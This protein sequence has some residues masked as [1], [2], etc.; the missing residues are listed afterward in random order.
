M[1][2]ALFAIMFALLLALAAT[3]TAKAL[4]VEQ[5]VKKAKAATVLIVVATNDGAQSGT[6]FAVQ[7]S[8]D[9][10]TV[11]TA[12]HVIE[13]ETQVNIIFDSNEKERYPAEIVRRDHV[14]DV[15][16]LKVHV[17]RR[18]T[19]ALESP[20]DVSE[21][22]QIVLIGYPLAT[23]EF[24]RIQG[25]ALQPSVHTGIV[26]AVR[27][28]GAVLQFDAATYHGDS[29]GP[30][31]DT[32]NG[33]VVAIVH[34]AELDPSYEARGLE[35]SLPGSSF[36][37]SSS[38]IASVLYETGPSGVAGVPNQEE[39]S[40]GAVAPSNVS[41]VGTSSSYR[42]GYGIPHEVVTGGDIQFGNE[43]NG[44]VES[45]AIDRL[46]GF[47]KQDNSL[48]LIPVSLDQAAVT[49]SQRLAGYCDDA[50]LNTLVFP[51]YSW[52]LTGGPRYNA[53][54]RLL[55][56]FGRSD[57]DGGSLCLRLLRDT[58][59]RRAEKQD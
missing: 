24:H 44:A 38:T 37:P 6:G 1:F 26:S 34:G 39:E 12:N 42:V 30:I 31:I 59:F 27:F 23:L 16:I 2:R 10:T 25:D 17:G 32:D 13:G 22:M 29:G 58:V 19:I 5:V 8:A 46:Q 33:R 51:S 48:Y 36:G 41:A 28:N 55:R 35:Q 18:P 20:D 14:K 45:A 54:G 21:G 47:L 4:T 50:R 43:I 7:S 3:S 9:S 52:G 57:S 15:A 11:V 49:D 56:I 40:T 53:Y